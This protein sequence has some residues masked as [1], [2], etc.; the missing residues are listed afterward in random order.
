MKLSEVVGDDQPRFGPIG[1][2]GSSPW[3]ATK[4]RLIRATRKVDL[5]R[6]A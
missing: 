3:H 5:P 2:G 6:L 1:L 4:K